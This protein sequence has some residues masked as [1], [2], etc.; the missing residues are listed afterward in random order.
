[1]IKCNLRTHFPSLGVPGIAAGAAFLIIRLLFLSPFKPQET[2]NLQNL[3]NQLV[4]YH[5]TLLWLHSTVYVGRESLLQ[6]N[7]YK[8]QRFEQWHMCLQWLLHQEG[9]PE[10][11]WTTKNIVFSKFE[12]PAKVEY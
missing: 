12:S 3:Q 10:I 7:L 2:L 8:G 4:L 11:D 6:W 9:R 5:T 1:M